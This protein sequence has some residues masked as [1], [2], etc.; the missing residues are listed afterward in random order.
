MAAATPKAPAPQLYV[1]AEE[2]RYA[3]TPELLAGMCDENTIGVVAVFGSTYTGEFEDVAGID[4][5]V[6]EL[7]AKNGW[8][9][10]VHVDGA[11]GAFVAPFIYPDLLFDFRLPNVASINVSGHKYGLVYPGLGWVLW[12][13]AEALPESIVFYCDYLGSLE[14]TITLNFSRGA[15][16]IIGQYYQLLRLGKAGYASIMGNL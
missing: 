16:Q 4:A 2:G 7:N 8:N 3:A 14:R 6:G 11:S 15:S 1:L 12:R 10:V 13:D 9:L 5:A